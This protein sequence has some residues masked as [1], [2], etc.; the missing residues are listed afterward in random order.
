[1]E[2]KGSL[3]SFIYSKMYFKTRLRERPSCNSQDW[4]GSLI[5]YIIQEHRRYG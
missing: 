1:M 2:R 3:G 4:P 5:F